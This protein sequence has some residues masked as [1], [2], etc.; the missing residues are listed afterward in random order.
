MTQSFNPFNRQNAAAQNNIAA[1]QT[2]PQQAPVQT[3]YLPAVVVGVP[4]NT[5]A[6]LP[7]N[8]ENINFGPSGTQDLPDG[9]H[10]VE[11]VPGDPKKDPGSETGRWFYAPPGKSKDLKIAFGLKIVES[12]D[13]KNVGLVCARRQKL[14]VNSPGSDDIVFKKIASI[15]FALMGIEKPSVE[16][17]RNLAGVWDE[18]M[19]QGT[20]GGQSLVG[21]R[22]RARVYDGRNMGPNGRPYKE[23][24][25]RPA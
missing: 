3:G 24:D 20:M 11:L 1:T 14:A 15:L 6:A 10:I 12:N 19:T 4:R 8:F 23:Y 9:E 18:F 5:F 17:K 2:V 16:D 25:F 7:A 22:C 21:L 13:P